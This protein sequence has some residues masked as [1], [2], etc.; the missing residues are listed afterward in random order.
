MAMTMMAMMS[1]PTNFLSVKD[2]LFGLLRA[3]S[4]DCGRCCT[5]A[6]EMETEMEMEIRDANEHD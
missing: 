6:M 1:L 5:A 4:L 3:A 2:F